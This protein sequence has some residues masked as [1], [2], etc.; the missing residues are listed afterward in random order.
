M[1][2]TN[3]LPYLIL[4]FLVACLLTFFTAVIFD[5]CTTIK[6]KDQLRASIWAEVEAITETLKET[7]EAGTIV[8]PGP[9]W[10]EL[11]LSM[12]EIYR[13]VTLRD[14]VSTIAVLRKCPNAYETNPELPMRPTEDE[15]IVHRFDQMQRFLAWLNMLDHS[16]RY[17]I[18][19]QTIYRTKQAVI[20]NWD[21]WKDCD[22]D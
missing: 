10:N 2:R 9:D 21:V 19:A 20:N 11:E 14:T 15:L 1:R 4:G 18:L 17:N 5:G 13:D 12:W 6:T 3:I 22:K 7:Y 16:S 8:K